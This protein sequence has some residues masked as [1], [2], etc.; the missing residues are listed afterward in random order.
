MKMSRRDQCREQAGNSSAVP[1][2]L[3]GQRPPSVSS[4]AVL[5][6]RAREIYDCSRNTRKNTG[7]RAAL[8]AVIKEQDVD[9]P[10]DAGI[11]LLAL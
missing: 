6:H 11:L 8:D 7:P 1:A 5:S 9:S 10:V 4:Y 3:A 2:R